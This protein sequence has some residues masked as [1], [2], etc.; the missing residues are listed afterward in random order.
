MPYCVCVDGNYS[1][2]FATDMGVLIGDPALPIVWLAFFFFL[3]IYI[4][5]PDFFGD[6]V[7]GYRRSPKGLRP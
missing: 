4:T 7:F 5:V 3:Q 1:G 2:F 6:I